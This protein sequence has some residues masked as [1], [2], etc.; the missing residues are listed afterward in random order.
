M[1]LIDRITT[2]VAALG[3][4]LCVVAFAISIDLGIGALV[5]AAVSIANWLIIRFVG[6]R[7]V[8]SGARGRTVLSLVL[9]S[10]MTL[11]LGACA[12]ILWT[13]R[14]DPG[15][16]MIGIGAMVLGV[17]FGGMHEALQPPALTAQAATAQPS[18]TD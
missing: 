6:A 4:V 5:G 12:A 17:V 7:L 8:A 13:G 18:E 11:V 16:F 9:V 1:T 3:V 15:G 14:V 2:Y 10:K